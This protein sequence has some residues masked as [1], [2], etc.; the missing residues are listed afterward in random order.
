MD[1]PLLLSLRSQYKKRKMRSKMNKKPNKSQ[2]NKKNLRFK[3]NQSSL[4][5][6]RMYLLNKLLL[7]KSRRKKRLQKFKNKSSRPHN[8]VS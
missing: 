8:P 3:K 7:E 4:S 6:K 2:W 1:S 5:K